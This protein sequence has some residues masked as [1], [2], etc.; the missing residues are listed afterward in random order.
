MIEKTFNQ[1]N[2][3]INYLLNLFNLNINIILFLHVI[4]MVLLSKHI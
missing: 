1:I 4:L 3:L 2:L